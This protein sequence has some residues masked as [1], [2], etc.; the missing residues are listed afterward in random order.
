MTVMEMTTVRDEVGTQ[1]AAAAKSV[2]VCVYTRCVMLCVFR[3]ALSVHVWDCVRVLHHREIE[4][5]GPSEPQPP[6]PSS[7]FL[8]HDGFLTAELEDECP[9]ALLKHS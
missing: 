4:C 3:G 9:P 8:S 5:L 1:R 2:C 6:T 7:N